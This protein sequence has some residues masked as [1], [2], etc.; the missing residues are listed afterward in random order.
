MI[1]IPVNDA[2]PNANLFEKFGRAPYFALFQKEKGFSKFLFN[3][4]LSSSG[5]VGAAATQ[6]LLKEGVRTVITNSLGP[7][8]L[9]ILE[10]ADVEIYK[11]IKGSMLKNFKKYLSFELENY[12][13]KKKDV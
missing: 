11:G 13:N 12:N 9:R 3:P 2:T 4:S 8:A 5:G 7:K 1:A 10:K 6:L